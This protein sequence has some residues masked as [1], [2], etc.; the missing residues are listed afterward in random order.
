MHVDQFESSPIENQIK[1]I[2]ETPFFL[3]KILSLIFLQG[4]DYIDVIS[5]EQIERR[6]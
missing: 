6:I 4:I 1:S 2:M 3:L 5:S